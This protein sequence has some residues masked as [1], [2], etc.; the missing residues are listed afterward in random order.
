M[1]LLACAGLIAWLCAPAQVAPPGALLTEA[2]KGLDEI[3]IEAAL[4][5]DTRQL[6][7]VQSLT[8]TNRTGQTQPQAVLRTWP[9]AFR[10]ADTSP[11]ATEEMYDACYPDGFSMGA[12]QMSAATAAIAGGEPADVPYRYADD[13]QTVLLLPLATP[14]QSGESVTLTLRYTVHIPRAAYRFGVHNGIWALGNAFAIPAVYENGAW[15]QDAYSPI[16]DPFISDCAN[17]A[18]SVTVPSGYACAGTGLRSAQDNVFTFRALAV[19]DLALVISDRFTQAREV[20]G[21]VEL[22][23]YATSDAYARELLGVMKAARAC[24]DGRYGAYPYQ[25]L[26]AAEV[27]FPVGGMEYPSLIMIASQVLKQG[28]QTVQQVVS[29]EVAHQWWYAVVGSDPAY[30]PWQ[31]EA[32][33]TFSTLEYFETAMGRDARDELERSDIQT[34]MRVTVPGSVTPGA[35]SDYFESLSQYALVVYNRGAA[36]FCALDRYLPGGLDEVL[37]TYYRRYA[38][39]RATREDFERLLG[40]VTGEDLAPLVTDYLDTLLAS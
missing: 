24:Y 12:L 23:A 11:V 26:C 30:Q 8:L 27:D 10:S 38:F 18:V 39:G 28:G 9:N 22:T 14:W 29:H 31:D 34:A 33:S 19:R 6:T 40:D 1:A 16:G 25:S 3:A 17:Y 20:A 37:K 4:D 2:S 21:G 15:R 5:P 32:L 35:P 7:V 36:L 13:A